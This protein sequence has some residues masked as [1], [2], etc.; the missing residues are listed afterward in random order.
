MQTKKLVGFTLKMLVALLVSLNSTSNAQNSLPYNYWT[1]DGSNA[2]NDSMNH[3]ALNPTFYNS[4]YSISSGS[5]NNSVGRSLS[6]SSASKMIVASSPFTLDTAVT[7]EFLFKGGADLN[8]TVQ[9]FGR[10]DGAVQIRFG[11][12]TLKFNTSVIPNG[13]SS[14]VSDNFYVDLRGVGRGSYGYYVDGN[15]HHFVF[16]YNAKT[17]VK[18]IWVDGECPLEFQKIVPAGKFAANATNANNN[19]MDVNTNTDYYK[20]NGE[21]DEVAFYKLSLHENI[22]YKHYNEFKQNKHYS[23]NFVNTVPPA[24][25]LISAG[26]DP[27]EYAPGHPT[28]TVSALDQLLT[29]P[30]P[31]YKPGNTLFPNIPM[32]NPARLA[33]LDQPN[34]STNKVITISKEIQ[35]QMVTNFNYTLVVSS[36]TGHGKFTDTTTYDGAW[37]KMANQNPSWKTS[38]VSYWDQIRPGSQ[39]FTS[40]DPYINCGCLP[41][42]SYLKN[43]QGQFIDRNGNVVSYKI[44][45]PQ[46]PLD[47]I[48]QD[49]KTQRKYL[50]SL[51]T[52]LTR[53][54]DV[55]FENGEVITHWTETGLTIDP[56][57]L[58]AK[59]ASGLD[60]S[61]YIGR[62]MGGVAGAYMSEY[63][64]LPQLSSTWI[65]HYQLTAHPSNWDWA[66]TRGLMTKRNGMYYRPDR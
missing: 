7:I 11:Y 21:I 44:L 14:A 61:K 65:Q 54:L 59:N 22:I 28:V 12:P 45:S 60:W 15:W 46:T 34:S 24:A 13:S 5:S 25:T 66:E 38:A 37:I 32:L 9:L 51:T 55:I 18:E 50:S 36:N 47:S 33:G 29:F 30:N 6:L 42:S 41:S 57:V 62:K 56:T 49:G 53:P 16:R 31:R 1:F 40:S 63:K 64:S 39:G 4:P 8:Q 2:M 3:N 58:A 35:K 17:G 10:R 48:V 27:M 23:F 43:A 26:I 19:T 52:A 20:F